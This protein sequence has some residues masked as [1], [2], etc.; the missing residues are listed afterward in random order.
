MADVEV[1][2]DPR[3]QKRPVVVDLY[4]NRTR[5]TRQEAERLRNGLD[6]ALATEE[7]RG[8]D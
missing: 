2:V 3:R 6:L 1:G 4:G 7:L 8:D 5:L